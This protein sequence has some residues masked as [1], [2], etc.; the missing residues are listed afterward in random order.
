[1]ERQ[2]CRDLSCE[3]TIPQN[4]PDMHYFQGSSEKDRMSV[5]MQE[6]RG[7]GL[8][9]RIRLMADIEDKRRYQKEDYFLSTQSH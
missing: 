3:T 2:P 8:L 1:V 5:R 6:H 7:I 9:K 4:D